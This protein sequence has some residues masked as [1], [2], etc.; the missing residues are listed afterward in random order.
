VTGKRLATG[1]LVPGRKTPLL[2]AL[3]LAALPCA[4]QTEL[5]VPPFEDAEA[6]ALAVLD[7]AQRSVEVAQ[8]NIRNERFVTKL[9]Q[10]RA[11]GVRVRIVIDAKNAAKPWNVLDDRI[12]AMGFDLV[13]YENTNHRYA[14][15]H[16]KFTVVD[17]AVVMTGSYN[18]NGTAQVVNDESMLVL[19][20]P[21]LAAA[22][23]AEFEE[24]WGAP[25]VAGVGGTP[26][27]QVH[28]APEDRPRDA[29]LA[30]IRGAQQ[31]IL[32]AMFSFKDTTVARA[33]RD[34]ARRGVEVILLTEKKQADTTRADE[35][36]ASGGARVI[37][38][39]NQSS[40]YSAMHSK[41][42]VIDD[43][44]VLAG[45]TNWTYTAFFSSNEDLLSLRDPD[46]ARR[47]TRAFG[48]LVRRYD[49]AGF[50][51]SDFGAPRAEGAVHLVV[52]MPRVD[53]A[54]ES[55]V[56]TGGHPALGD[57]DPAR[58]LVLGTTGSVFPSWAGSVRLPANT[59][60][61]WKAVVRR[62]DGTHTWELGTDRW[63]GTD[64]YGVDSVVDVPFRDLVDVELTAT[65]PPMPGAELR[66]VG[67]DP[68]LGGWDP[69]L[70]WPLN[71]TAP[72]VFSGRIPLPGR[73]VTYAKLVWVDAAG[74]VVWE[75]GADRLL[76]VHDQDAP[77]AWDLGPFRTQ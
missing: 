75:P 3:L 48:A 38:G 28:F 36:V 60:I 64:P 16:H 77:Q 30:A 4:A 10:L 45:A 23:Q 67:A 32:V 12:E 15:M 59:W 63:I 31:R 22:Y 18:W 1:T 73:A 25:E 43:A 11:R 2:A 55:V 33:L 71:E 35:T 69:A 56:I 5:Y 65:T 34:A 57:W 26:D 46:L 74:A 52:R 6:R 13:R 14:I 37:V 41:F 66:L 42:A 47:Y 9:D 70:G 19:H 20:D 44:L 24:L 72:G 7:G 51:A 68:A 61:P 17:D 49:P 76:L 50:V 29:V 39:A 40:A 62:A 8:Y 21:A 58:G 53:P 27:A 54:T